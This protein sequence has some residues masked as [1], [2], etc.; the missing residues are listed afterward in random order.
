MFILGGSDAKFQCHFT[1]DVVV[2][3]VVVVVVVV[4]VARL[5][6]GC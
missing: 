3:H 5:R 1:K 2:H 6:R 4:V